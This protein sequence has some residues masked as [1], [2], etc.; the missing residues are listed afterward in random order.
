MLLLCSEGEEKVWMIEQIS[1]RSHIMETR[2][3]GIRSAGV[4]L[5]PHLLV[6]SEDLEDA[7]SPY[8]SLPTPKERKPFNRSRCLGLAI[9]IIILLALCLFL[10]VRIDLVQAVFSGSSSYS[11]DSSLVG[12]S[13]GTLNGYLKHKSSAVPPST[14]RVLSRL[15]EEHLTKLERQI[16]LREKDLIASRSKSFSVASAS[17]SSTSSAV[18]A[19]GTVKGT[20]PEPIIPKASLRSNDVKTAPPREFSES[21]LV[22]LLTLQVEKV[23][24]LKSEQHLVMETDPLAI[25][26]I[27]VLQNLAREYVV[28]H[29]GPEP[30][31]VEMVVSYPASMQRMDPS[32]PA[33]GVIKVRLAPLEYMPYAVYYFL[34][35]VSNWKG[36]AFHRRAGHVLQAMVH[37]KQTGLAFQEYS[38]SFPHQQFTLGFAGRPGGPEFYISILDNTENHGPGSQGSNTEADTCFGIIEEGLDVV[39]QM[40]KQPGA[41]P[42]SGFIS[43]PEHY[44]K[45]PTL[46][47][48]R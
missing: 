47:L 40:K 2:H 15:E 35:I 20:P 30:Y 34:D 39:Q 31:I 23:R 37:A 45:I 42:P 21:E 27:A 25:A 11:I 4:T 5:P 16:K 1:L 6:H 28:H 14:V 24:R 36:G 18:V 10:W 19:G 29:Y 48:L 22:K 46:R 43:P 32:M 41:H 9:S 17:A 12:G 38:P 3:R 44:I 26:E 13:I 7:A 8:Y 33:Q